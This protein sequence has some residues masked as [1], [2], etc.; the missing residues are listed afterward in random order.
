MTAP[1]SLPE[2]LAGHA[3]A[4]PEAPFLFFPEGLHWRWWSWGRVAQLAAQWARPLAGLGAGTRVGFA[5]DLSPQALVL[6]LAVLSTGLVPVP[7]AGEAVAGEELAGE[8]TAGAPLAGGLSAGEPPAGAPFAGEPPGGQSR[9]PAGA[10]HR[11]GMPAGCAA[12]LEVV[13][14]ESILTSASTPPRPAAGGAR[15]QPGAGIGDREISP[16]AWLEAAARVGSAI[17]PSRQ[18]E[19]LVL[20]R[21]LAT[22]AGRIL[23]AWATVAGAALV[24]EPDAASYL[25]TLLWARP[26]VAHGSAAELAR[27]RS[28]VESAERSS[29]RTR[30]ARLRRRSS[31]RPSRQGGQPP[32]RLRTL[33]QDEAPEPGE[34]AFWQDRGTRLV[35]LPVLR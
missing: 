4:D 8:A 2:A 9:E 17:G 18:R 6:D 33:F 3:A 29:L 15:P 24:L 20:G 22:P 23:T 21:A 32:G 10:L 28:A 26:T 31:R 16:H 5:G 27:L 11:T 34:I 19:I 35:Q 7:L 13:D 12:W 1:A 25:R 30:L 14:G